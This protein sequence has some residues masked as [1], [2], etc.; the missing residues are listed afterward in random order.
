MPLRMTPDLHFHSPEARQALMRD[1]LMRGE[2]LQLATLASEFGISVDSARRDLKALETQGFGRCIRGG[3]LPVARV[4]PPTLSRLT[5]DVDARA[6]IVAATLPLIEDGM[7]L[8]MDGGTTVLALAQALPHSPGGLVVTP[9]PVVAQVTLEKGIPTQLIGG[10][11]SP[12]G[13][14]AVGH[15]AVTQ[16]SAV[17][18]DIAFLGACG[19]DAARG[20]TSDDADEAD[21]KR[22]MALCAH[23][24]WVPTVAAKIG[25]VTRHA[26]LPLD[27]ITG[28]VTDATPAVTQ[29]Y[30]AANIEVIHA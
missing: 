10:R 9:S 28:L 22:A 30:A 25:R 15:S 14:I 4:A 2:T 23:A 6:R 27:A 29:P 17:A 21:V 20:L 7:V 5:Q 11:L 8:M 1:R 19:I 12:S 13:A 3:A 24:T 26:V 16:V 18:A